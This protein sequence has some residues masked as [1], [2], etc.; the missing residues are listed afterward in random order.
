MDAAQSRA[1]VLRG[2]LQLSFAAWFL[3]APDA[4]AQQ[5]QSSAVYLQFE[6]PVIDLPRTQSIVLRA[7]I[8]GT[9]TRVVFERTFS[10][11][12]SGTQLDMRDDGSSPDRTASDG[13]YAV[14][15]S[16]AQLLPAFLASDVHRPFVGF[17]K[18]FSGNTELF[19]SNVFAEVFSAE[20]PLLPVI[21]PA[22]DVQHTLYVA[23]IHDSAFFTDFDAQRIARRFY[24]FFQDSF[25]FLNVLYSPGHFRNRSHGTVRN[26]VTGIGIPL[27]DNSSAFGSAGRLMGMSLFP[28]PGLFDGVDTSYQHELG[29]QWINFL[30]R[31]PL[32][33]SIPHWPVSSLAS[34]IMGWSTLGGQGLNF[35][36]F[37]TPV[38]GGVQLL[39][40]TEAP[41]FTDLDLYLM[42][43]LPAN[44][45]GQH[46]V[47]TDQTLGNQ[48][49]QQCNGQ[50][51]STPFQPVT[52][53]DVIAEHG[54]R[55]P[56]AGSSPK[57][58]TVATIVVSKDGLLPPEALAFYSFFARRAE[59]TRQVAFH[60]GFSKGLA[61]PFRISTRGLG[62]L[63]T[64][65]LQGGPDFTLS[66]SP[67]THTAT[68]G[69]P[70]G[71][72]VTVASLG[73]P[74]GNAVTFSCSGLPSG[75]SCAFSP[76]SATPGANPVTVDLRISA[77]ASS[78]LLWPQTN[79]NGAAA[80]QLIWCAAFLA[81][82]VW[83]TRGRRCPGS[84]ARLAAVALAAWILAACGG[85]A[86][87]SS[88]PSGGASGGATSSASLVT[89]TVT[90]TGSSGTST[91]S[92]TIQ[93]RM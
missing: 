86:G 64:E 90:V 38:T 60:S 67:P 88:T 65:L 9:P 55:V 28:I 8:T 42:G 63:E 10:S 89:H 26:D 56:D 45:V 15:I 36:C 87:T 41:V 37:L 68:S 47:I 39:R 4:I 44:Q 12:S 1:S 25:D 57:Q 61:N 19:R 83:S 50:V 91:R 20:I 30:R 32:E 80:R 13:E 70:A 22:A 27:F 51:L 93:V 62:S 31:T 76:V 74:F 69:Q 3:F 78:A 34:G 2:A 33:V 21:T 49:L 43:L 71:F 11:Q 85:G 40:Q 84:R 72:T 59:E 24:Q 52:V 54:P 23:N 53:G 77:P 29:H 92:A 82:A 16:T 18:A 7:K 46:I 6:P 48:I 79:L 35:P 75:A 14:S 17:L 66:V 81:L 73:A 5:A 58:F